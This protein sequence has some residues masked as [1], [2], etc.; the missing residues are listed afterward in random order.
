MHHIDCCQYILNIYWPILDDFDCYIWI[1][2]KWLL[3]V[4]IS[5]GL[6]NNINRY[7]FKNIYISDV[8]IYINT[9]II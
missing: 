2:N 5:S 9:I 3:I 7:S 4:H 8:E 6:L 1:H